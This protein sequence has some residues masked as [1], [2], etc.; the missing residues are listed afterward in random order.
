MLTRRPR[1]HDPTIVNVP[2]HVSQIVSNVMNCV[3]GLRK[4]NSPL[5]GTAMFNLGVNV[6]FLTMYPGHG[7]DPPVHLGRSRGTQHL[8]DGSLFLELP[9]QTDGYPRVGGAYCVA[10]TTAT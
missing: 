9:S 1:R 8:I 5:F 3:W 4:R 7:A 2:I 10:A 6:L